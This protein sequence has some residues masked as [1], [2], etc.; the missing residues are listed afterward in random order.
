MISILC[1]MPCSNY[2]LIP[3]LDLWSKERD[4]YNFTGLNKV[5]CHPP[6]A[7]WSRLKH[8]SKFDKKEKDLFKFCLDIVNTN[9]GIIEH[10]AGSSAFKFY[11]IK[12]TLSINQHWFGFPCRKSTWLYS[13]G[14][15]FKSHPLSFDAITHTISSSSR[16]RSL[17]ELSNRKNRSL[18]PLAFCQ[19]LVDSVIGLS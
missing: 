2:L 5:I 11:N 3:G 16:S 8:F 6:C 19:F 15:I 17:P 14:V 12:P 10:P 7:Q 9:G 1:T 13:S 4:A 18:M